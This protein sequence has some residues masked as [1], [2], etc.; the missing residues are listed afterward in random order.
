MQTNITHYLPVIEHAKSG[1][2]PAFPLDN[3]NY[4]A[5]QQ[6]KPKPLD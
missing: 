1:D 4:L 2:D 3:R 6:E 5:I